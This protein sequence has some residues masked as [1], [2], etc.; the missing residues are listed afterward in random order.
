M[1]LLQR[2]LGA[3]TF[4]SSFHVLR[5]RGAIGAAENHLPSSALGDAA[6]NTCG[7][8]CL[9]GSGTIHAGNLAG[10]GACSHWLEALQLL[11][12]HLSLTCKLWTLT[13]IKHTRYTY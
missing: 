9:A 8:R 4:Q 12:H 5:E 11:P 13:D 7:R 3:A 2:A 6:A 10:G 1:A